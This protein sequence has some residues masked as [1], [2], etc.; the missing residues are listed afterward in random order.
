MKDLI[1]AYS[2][3]IEGLLKSVRV[4]DREGNELNPF[5]GIEKV[6]E[7]IMQTTLGH[8]LIFIGNGGSAAFSSHMAIDFWKNGNMKAIAFNDTSLLTCLAMTMAMNISL[9]SL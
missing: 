1:E 6:C 5:V 2:K 7:L 8:K 9:K 3:K 4:T